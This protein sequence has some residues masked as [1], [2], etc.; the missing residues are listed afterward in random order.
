VLGG[1]YNALVGWL[2]RRGYDEGYTAILVVVGVMIT[3]AGIVV[4]DW[5]AA[6]L[7]LG[8]FASSGFWMVMGSWWR[9]VRARRAGQE[10]Q[11]EEVL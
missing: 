11:R 1:L 6:M 4:L 8:A 3:L 10:A 2:E 9:H 5:G 7:V